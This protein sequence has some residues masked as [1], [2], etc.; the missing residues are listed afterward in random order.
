MVG[1]EG[2]SFILPGGKRLNFAAIQYA[3]TGPGGLG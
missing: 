1:N 3:K 2:K